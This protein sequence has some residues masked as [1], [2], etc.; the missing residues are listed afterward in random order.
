M[1]F[2]SHKIVKEYM[3]EL[4]KITDLREE[5]RK[6]LADTWDRCLKTDNDEERSALTIAAK[7]LEQQVNSLTNKGSNYMLKIDQFNGVR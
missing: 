7:N 5:V 1:G 2:E 3:E 4:A 6:Q